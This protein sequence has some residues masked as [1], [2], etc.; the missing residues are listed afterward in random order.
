MF[1]NWCLRMPISV[2]ITCINKN[3]KQTIVFELYNV[4]GTG[5]FVM[6]KKWGIFGAIFEEF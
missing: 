6:I 5:A 1:L 3:R 4:A 2:F